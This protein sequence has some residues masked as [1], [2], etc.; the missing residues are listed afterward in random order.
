M[1]L[2]T[3]HRLDRREIMDDFDLQ[4]MEL[5][6]TLKDLDRINKWLGGNKIT[7]KGL[8]KIF[9]KTTHQQPLRILDIGCGN[10]SLLREVAQFGRKKGIKMKLLG[11]DA[12]KHAI[13]IARK[14]TREFP[15]ISFDA[16]DVFSEKFRNL[17]A[18]VILC[19]LTLHHFRDEEIENLLEIFVGVAKQGI[20]I[21]DLQRSKTAYRL[22]KAFCAVFIRNDIAKKDGL[23]SIL[24]A[25][26]KGDLQ[27]YGRNLKV[28]QQKI[29][30]KWAFR[31]QWVLIK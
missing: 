19:T 6:K 3:K 10:G 2:N 23:T 27:W 7:L 28:S 8:E 25:F 4:G 13:G 1:K 31:Y 14:N 11:I 17:E 29:S 26:K 18:D 30:W 24:R 5:K 21:N 9:D 15:E 16:L 22:F 12:N 20:V